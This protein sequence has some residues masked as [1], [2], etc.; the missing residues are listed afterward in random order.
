MHAFGRDRQATLKLGEHKLVSTEL[1]IAT[2][3]VSLNPLGVFAF[4]AQ[5]VR[6]PLGGE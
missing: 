5:G 1:T 6:L 2:N 4:D 3:Q